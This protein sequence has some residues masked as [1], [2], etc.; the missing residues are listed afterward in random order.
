MVKFIVKRLAMMVATLFVI[1]L[2]TF[3]IMHAIPGGP[4]S[5]GK[6]LPEAI[7]AALDEKYNLNAPLHVQ[8]WDYLQG[9]LHFDLGP[10]FKYEGMSVNVLIA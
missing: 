9:V 8:F 4:Y 1:L 6:R 3:L 5:A 10:S 2:I 7:Q